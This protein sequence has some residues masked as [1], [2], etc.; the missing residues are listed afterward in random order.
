MHAHNAWKKTV[1]ES[2]IIKLETQLNKD[3]DE[4]VDLTERT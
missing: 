4:F 1:E 2:E 3:M